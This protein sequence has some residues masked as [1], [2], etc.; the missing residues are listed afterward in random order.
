VACWI[1]ALAQALNAAKSV[2]EGTTPL[3]IHVPDDGCDPTS[4][5]ACATPCASACD[6]S[7]L[8]TGNIMC[9]SAGM[10]LQ[11]R[12]TMP[13]NGAAVPARNHIAP[14]CLFNGAQSSGVGPT[15]N[16]CR[17]HTSLH[18]P[19]VLP[20]TLAVI[21][22]TLTVLALPCAD[23]IGTARNSAMTGITNARPLLQHFVPMCMPAYS[24][25]CVWCHLFHVAHTGVDSSRVRKGLCSLIIAASACSITPGQ[26]GSTG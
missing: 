5:S 3:T 6:H 17:H 2:P 9:F 20:S 15:S 18:L 16:A 12:V 19:Y 21:G 1:W 22:T 11:E 7:A 25:C 23:A 14:P 24:P 26:T 13:P 8:K 4:A 10:T